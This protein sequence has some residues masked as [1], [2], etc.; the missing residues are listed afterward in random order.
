MPRNPFGWPKRSR[1]RGVSL[2][3]LF[4]NL[5]L[6][7]LIVLALAYFLDM[8]SPAVNVVVFI[9]GLIFLPALVGL[10][11]TRRS[12]EYVQALWN[13]ATSAAFAGLV[14]GM[15]ATQVGLIAIG[16]G[17]ATRQQSDQLHSIPLTLPFL[18]FF[19]VLSLQRLRRGR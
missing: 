10:F 4:A 18:A 13:S 11:L 14:I 5:G 1:H 19:L 17:N 2:F 16:H 9:A 12:D 6:A 15:V 3:L 8:R 7:S